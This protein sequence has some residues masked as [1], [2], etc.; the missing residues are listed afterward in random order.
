MS[1]MVVIEIQI[2]TEL[3]ETAEKI[4]T[5]QGYTLEE[6]VVQ[7]LTKTVRFGRI[8][9]EVTEEMLAEARAN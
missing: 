6:A 2:D 7:F 8:P 9:F 3:M 5:A 4:L 1:N